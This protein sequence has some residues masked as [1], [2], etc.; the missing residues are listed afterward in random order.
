[1]VFNHT[2]LNDWNTRVC[3][4]Q[5]LNRSLIPVVRCLGGLGSWR[6]MAETS[7]E[8]TLV[9]IQ[10]NNQMQASLAGVSRPSQRRMAGNTISIFREAV[11]AGIIYYLYR[12]L[13]SIPNPFN[14]P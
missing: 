9:D 8:P 14:V 6:V 1:M 12:P 4:E 2:F 11:K 7:A 3:R 5:R 13:S 10:L